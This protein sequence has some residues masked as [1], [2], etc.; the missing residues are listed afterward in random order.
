MSSDERCNESG[1][2]YSGRDEKYI[3][4]TSLPLLHTQPCDPHQVRTS[5]RVRVGAEQSR[6]V[7]G[8]RS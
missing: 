8:R 6:A 1:L 4:T 5:V 2:R 7:A 3:S